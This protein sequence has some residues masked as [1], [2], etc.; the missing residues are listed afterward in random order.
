MEKLDYSPATQTGDSEMASFKSRITLAAN[1]AGRVTYRSHELEWL[2]KI[3]TI[4]AKAE[5]YAA[6][7]PSPRAVF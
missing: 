3:A 6:N 4:R 2:H 5:S 7:H 1:R